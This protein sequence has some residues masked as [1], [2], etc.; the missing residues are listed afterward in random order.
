[1]RYAGAVSRLLAYLVDA[2]LLVAAATGTIATVALV[3][4]VGGAPLDGLARL[5]A[6]TYAL[7]LPTVFAAGCALFWALAG[8]TPG[9]A[10]LGLR[11]V[12]LDGRPVRWPAALLRAVVL[13]YFPV[14]AAWLLVD[15]RRQALHDKLARTAVTR[16]G[17]AR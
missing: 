1:M 12:A 13:A 8:R 7:G 10:L 17:D 16:R 5:L 4:Q 9:M 11:V 2:L 6:A 3:A 15:R 14:G